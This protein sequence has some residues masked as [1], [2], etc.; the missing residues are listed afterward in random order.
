MST[1]IQRSYS[2]DYLSENA[3]GPRSRVKY[4]RIPNQTIRT[5]SMISY[6]YASTC[7]PTLF[8]ELRTAPYD[9]RYWTILK[10]LEEERQALAASKAASTAN[11]DTTTSISTSSHNNNKLVLV[12][13]GHNHLEEAADAI[14][15]HN[16]SLAVKSGETEEQSNQLLGYLDD[17]YL[18]NDASVFEDWQR[19]SALIKEVLAASPTLISNLTT[20][21]KLVATNE[22]LQKF[23][24][25]ENVE[26][27]IEALKKSKNSRK[28]APINECKPTTYHHHYNYNSP[29]Y[30]TN[31]AECYR[32][33]NMVSVGCEPNSKSPSSAGGVGAVGAVG[34]KYIIKEKMNTTASATSITHSSSQQQTSTSTSSTSKSNKNN[35]SNK[36]ASSIL[37]KIDA[38]LEKIDKKLQ[39]GENKI[40][41]LNIFV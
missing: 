23:M 15:E 26:Q 7:M 21:A 31:Y 36:A 16:R 33:M 30:L 25:K 35:N 19:S 13:G 37:E 2:M 24:S 29:S 27:E 18:S 9:L 8:G 4:V 38:E 1:F 34:A 28:T 41:Y 14:D 22:E 3:G 12:N 10:L 17:A 11:A 5:Q 32:P 20:A 6:D 39:V 40:E